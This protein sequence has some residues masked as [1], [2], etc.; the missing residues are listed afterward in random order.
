MRLR[1]QELEELPTPER[2]VVD[3]AHPAVSWK[4]RTLV[5]NLAT[6]SG[7]GYLQNKYPNLQFDQDADGE[8]IIKG[9]KEKE[10]RKLDPS[11]LE[12]ADVSD[13]AYDV[14][15]GVAEGAAALGGAVAGNIP[16]AMGAAGMSAAALEALRQKLGQY[17]GVNQEL[18]P[19]QIGAAG[20]GS[21]L[22]TPLVGVG[23]A[24]GG[25]RKA[26]A[27]GAETVL[28]KGV[29]ERIA[30]GQ[31]SE[32]A[33]KGVLKKGYEN[34]T[35]GALPRLAEVTSGEKAKVFKD[36]ISNLDV[37]EKWKADPDLFEQAVFKSGKDFEEAI[38]SNVK[39]AG[40]EMEALINASGSD[41]KVDLTPI[42]DKYR[43]QID[44]LKASDFADDL[45]L[46]GRLEEAFDRVFKIKRAPEGGGKIEDQ[47][48]DF[49][50][51]S[52]ARKIRNIFMSYN[53]GFRKNL[54]GD[55]LADDMVKFGN[56]GYS[57]VNEAIDNA[58]DMK[59]P[60]KE[61]A[62]K[63]AKERYR[64]ALA[65]EQ[66]LNRFRK[67]DRNTGL[68]DYSKT[69]DTLRTLGNDSKAILRN[70]VEKI[71]PDIVKQADLVQAYSRLND[72]SFFP[73][74]GTATSTSRTLAMGTLGAGA[75]ALSQEGGLGGGPGTVVGIGAGLLGLGPKAWRFYL[76]QGKRGEDFL[77]QKFRQAGAQV[78]RDLS[79]Y[80]NKQMA[81]QS[82]WGTMQSRSGQKNEK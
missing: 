5:K 45:E 79:K 13:I 43:A 15:A 81:A 21:A 55:R 63:K 58:M 60:G 76:S 41:F 33:E 14:G 57:L 4:D 68:P 40:R 25:V 22:L 46:A 50:N 27:E 1:L 75:G 23:P 2:T 69:F 20:V 19:M 80:L 59:L 36:Y 66:L 52:D 61:G 44:E 53:R 78:P 3:E 16:G 29:A 51:F 56:E 35:R 82:I 65:S 48:R 18:D 12:L 30:Q 39:A 71:N 49:V 64:Q 77:K 37:M 73:T 26:L 8:V 10:W 31:M 9:K 34:F 24:K 54:T 32:L 7:L 11:S 67:V 42:V 72:P 62:F 28:G 17:A 6:G 47:F 38:D 74:S 70:A